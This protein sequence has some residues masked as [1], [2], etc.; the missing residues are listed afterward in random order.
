M[1]MRDFRDKL[2]VEITPQDINK[3]LSLFAQS[4]RNAKLRILRAVFN[5]G[6]KRGYL[7]LN[8]VARLDFAELET[9][10]VEV[11]SVEQTT[12]FLNATLEMYPEPNRLKSRLPFSSGVPASRLLDANLGRSERV[13]MN[14][15]WPLESY[16]AWP[17]GL[18]P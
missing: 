12:A 9:K 13:M 18:G 6:I 8:P 1:A 10:E 15:T 3:A 4:S 17:C 16:V 2:I 11:F 7:T 14:K 5:L